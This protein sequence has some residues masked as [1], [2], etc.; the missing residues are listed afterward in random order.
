[1]ANNNAIQQNNQAQTSFSSEEI[2]SFLEKNGT[3]D[4]RGVE[5][6]MRNARRNK[7]LTRHCYTVYQ[8]KDGRWYSYLPDPVKG[9]KKIVKPTREKLE[10]QICAYYESEEDDPIGSMTLRR[11]Y[12][13][14]LEYKELHVTYS[15]VVR[16]K[17]D[18][19]RYYENSKIVDVPIRKLKKIDI[20][21][22]VHRMIKEY[23]MGKHQ[24]G[25]FSLIIKQELEYAVDLEIIDDNPFRH[26]K[27]DR[28]RVLTPEYKKPDST[29]V[30]TREEERLIIEHAWKAF[31]A[32][33]NYVQ[34]FVP[35]AIVFMFY[36]GLR[37][38]EA[39]ALRFEDIDGDTLHVRRM[40][41][42]SNGEIIDDTK[43][44]FGQREVPLVPQALEVIDAVMQRREK[45]R[46]DT[47]GYFFSPTDK[48]LNTYTSIQKSFT[49]YCRDLKIEERSAHK[50][51]KTF[52]SAL[53]SAGINLNTVRQIVGHM[54][55]KTTLNNY[56]YD[57][58]TDTEKN[59][60]I[61]AA[62]A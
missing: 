61:A 36:T 43:G 4:L 14:W 32:R 53:L 46:M 50:A 25:N 11:L 30:F 2:L 57:R 21:V 29:Q 13:S 59:L 7:I 55:E 9:R 42:Y 19:Q 47:K 20:D 22:W 60:M 26:V 10:D 51:R 38:G 41:R 52:V 58:N 48:P 40:V 23:N 56:L 15:T 54:D 12:P 8:G 37:V 35:L 3:I 27:I 1:M 34:Q 62:L 5:E 16:I 33:K 45:Y 28:K 31:N 49:Q 39:A 18:W 6:E 17:K 24:Y 44:T